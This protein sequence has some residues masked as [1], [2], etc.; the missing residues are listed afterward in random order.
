MS[1]CLSSALSRCQL[2]AISFQLKSRSFGG[3]LGSF[4]GDSGVVLG[5]F[6]WRLLFIFIRLSGSC[7]VFLHSWAGGGLAVFEE[8][9]SKCREHRRYVAVAAAGVEGFA[10]NCIR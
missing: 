10:E 2:S 9:A 8:A 4:D 3:C 7:R 5:C 6:Y 1:A